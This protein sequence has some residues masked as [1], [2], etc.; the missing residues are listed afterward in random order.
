MAKGE[1]MTFK[2]V[3][4]LLAVA[5]L[6]C[7]AVAFAQKGPRSSAQP[8]PQAQQ[9]QQVQLDPVALTILIKSTMMAVYH[10]NATGNYS[11]LRDLGS[12]V[13]RE[14][15]DQAALTGIFANL[16]SRSVNLS[17]VL[18]VQPSLTKQPEVT[19]QGQL[20]LVGLFPTQ[21]LQIQFEFL[22]LQLDGNWRLDGIAVDAV[23]TAQAA[24]NPAA[25]SQA[26]PRTGK[27]A[28]R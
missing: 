22:F 2:Y 19:G 13:F 17:P 4:G 16:R 21:P 25:A 5:V 8:Q 9:P 12:P 15:Y 24:S 18:L 7:V 23:P 27:P 1:A 28:T 26:A 10:A 14:R 20:H 3:R 6:G 11:V